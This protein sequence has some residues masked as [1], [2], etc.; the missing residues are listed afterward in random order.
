MMLPGRS[1]L[2]M[3]LTTCLMALAGCNRQEK[4][5]AYMPK[6]DAARQALEK[7]LKSWQDGQK[8]GTI[9]SDAGNIQPQDFEWSA[10]KKLTK[11]EIGAEQA[12][13]DGPTRYSVKITVGTKSKDAVYVIVGKDPLWVF[14]EEDYN[15]AGGG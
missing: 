11:F 2:A 13:G 5:E 14:R 15:R 12:A 9:K 7:A 6:G 4:V 1:K 3:C 8:M 10:G